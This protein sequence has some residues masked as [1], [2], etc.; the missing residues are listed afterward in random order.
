LYLRK[1]TEGFDENSLRQGDILIGIPFPLLERK[2]LNVLGSIALDYDY[3][4][5]PVI[6]SR[7]HT[8]RFDNNWVTLQTPA[9]FCTCA[10]TSNC[11]DLEPRHGQIQTRMVTLARLRPISN[12]ISGDPVKLA[13]LKANKDPRR[14]PNDPGYLDYFY[15]EPD[16]LLEN[17]DW[18]VEYAQVV[19]IPA[20]DVDLLLKKKIL[21]LDDRTRVK[22]K[23]KLA[24][25][26][27]R[28]NDEEEQAGLEDPWQ[29]A[30]PVPPPAPEAH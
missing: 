16:E 8:H 10:V 7:T 27:S 9:R 6:S 14:D 26:Q 12:E 23:I 5:P 30:P 18:N 2:S 22:F 17:K 1:G 28:M 11:C 19:S 20:S 13:S 21:Q 29:E 15:L 3:T 4:L 25:T 24:F